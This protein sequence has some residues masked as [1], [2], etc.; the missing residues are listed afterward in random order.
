MSSPLFDSITFKPS[1]LTNSS[2]PTA[3]R[4]LL[5]PKSLT[6]NAKILFSQSQRHNNSELSPSLRSKHS[7]LC[8]LLSLRCLCH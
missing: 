8:A 6:D 1:P 7:S 4:H 3:D 2:L 5:L